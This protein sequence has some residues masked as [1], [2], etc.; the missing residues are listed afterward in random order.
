MLSAAR[1]HCRATQLPCDASLGHVPN[2]PRT[3]PHPVRRATT[4]PAPRCPHGERDQIYRRVLPDRQARC[5]VG[6]DQ[7]PA[8]LSRPEI[9]PSQPS[10]RASTTAA[11][12]TRPRR[13]RGRPEPATSVRSRVRVRP[14][15]PA[16]RGLRS[17]RK[18]NSFADE[19][20][21]RKDAR[22]H[23]RGHP[24]GPYVAHLRPERS[25]AQERSVNG[26]VRVGKNVVAV[27]LE[28]AEHED[29]PRGQCRRQG[30]ADRAG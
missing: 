3:S 25:E 29:G 27:L 30:S 12:H 10:L 15:P 22:Q 1:R 7:V 14:T 4:T 2:T 21:A 16:H 6:N 17:R 26:G 5:S 24:P 28:H 13:L 18:P 20:E 23:Q 8:G 11:P 9:D 19:R